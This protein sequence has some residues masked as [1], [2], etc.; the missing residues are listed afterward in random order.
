MAKDELKVCGL[1][2]V[3]AIAERRREDIIR[4]YLV[5]ERVRELGP[6]LRWC[7][8]ERRAYHVVDADE[9]ERVADTIHHEGVCILARPRA[10]PSLDALAAAL[11]H[12]RGPACVLFLEDVRNPHN[13]GAILRTAAHF[14]VRAVLVDHG[15]DVSFTPGLLRT[16]EGGAEAVDVV[17]IEDPRDALEML[18][19]RGFTILATSSHA[20][21]SIYDLELPPRVVFLMGAEGEGLS[22]ALLGFAHERVVVSGTGEVESLNVSAATAVLTSEHWRTHRG[23]RPV[24]E[25]VREPPWPTGQDRPRAAPR[26]PT[27]GPRDRSSPSHPRGGRGPRSRRR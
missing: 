2:A 6:L 4:V 3:L 5:E 12:E 26:A 14:G 27:R 20:R 8:A 9:L 7:A 19:E 16:A 21:R 1:N 18:V 22:K 23:R 11:D 25:A 24:H 13:L 10:Q 15:G 17:S